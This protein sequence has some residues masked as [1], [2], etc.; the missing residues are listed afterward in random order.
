MTSLR[1][2]SARQGGNAMKAVHACRRHV[3]GLAEDDAWRAFLEKA[4]GKR[5]LREMD[6]REL[7]Q[8]IDALHANGAPRKALAA[9][10]K[11]GPRRPASS[12]KPWVWKAM[13][14]WRSLHALGA[15]SEP[16]ERALSAFCKRQGCGEA[17]AWLGPEQATKVIDALKAWCAREGFRLGGS[18]TLT[19]INDK[20]VLAGMERVT[21]GWR[22]KLLLVHALLAKLPEAAG[23]ALVA[24]APCATSDMTATELD[25]AIEDLGAAVRRAK[26]A[27]DGL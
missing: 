4:T 2:G 24:E 16:S 8:V 13:A 17:L 9:K 21:E 7:G 25:R 11:P 5:S 3:A 12:T 20:R 6:G 1:Q 23:A 26:A 14:L 15:V 18:P 27:A 10:A 19:R 22:A